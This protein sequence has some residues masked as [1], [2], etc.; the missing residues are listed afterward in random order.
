VT[1]LAQPSLAAGIPGAINLIASGN[2]LFGLAPTVDPEQ[3][4][5]A[6]SPN[7]PFTEQIE[8]WGASAH[9][10]ATIGDAL[11]FTSITSYR[12]WEALRDQDID[13][14]GIDRAY[15]D[16]YVVGFETLTQEFRLHG[17]NGRLDWLVG[18]FYG[19]ED[20]NL[21]DTIRFGA[22]ANR[23]VDFLGAGLGGVTP[24]TAG[25][26]GSCCATV[27]GSGG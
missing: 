6:Y 15:R 26:P 7:R 2:G 17:E 12:D 27:R 19:K 20:L 18:A 5:G 16:D 10:D 13:F 25:P 22:D 11:D 21:T 14:S 8:E 23:Y 1:L 24:G 4:Q 9:L 3:R